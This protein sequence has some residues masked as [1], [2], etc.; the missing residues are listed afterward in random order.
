M[1]RC[2]SL[3]RRKRPSCSAS[4]NETQKKPP[5]SAASE[6]ARS[7]SSRTV[8]SLSQRRTTRRVGLR[9]GY[10]G[11]AP[12]PCRRRSRPRTA[13]RRGAGGPRPSRRRVS[14]SVP[15][16]PRRRSARPTQDSVEVAP[17]SRKS[18]R[19]SASPS[20]FDNAPVDRVP[21]PEQTVE[22]R[23]SGT[24]RGVPRWRA[25]PHRRHRA[26]MPAAWSFGPSP[27]KMRLREVRQLRAS[28]R[29]WSC[30]LLQGARE[31]LPPQPA[32]PSHMTSVLAQMSWED[33]P[34]SSS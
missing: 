31:L 20:F 16:T 8:R 21:D 18:S 14:A 19:R 23:S 32:S 10:I 4:P 9:G 34:T 5:A 6:R 24:D 11:H 33:F 3:K 28:R 26:L 7:A 12:A 22:V 17:S 13:T 15:S 25:Q 1:V 27:G 29:E 2:P 30:H